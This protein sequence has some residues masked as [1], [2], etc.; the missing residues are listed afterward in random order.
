MART[1]RGRRDRILKWLS[2]VE[3][4]IRLLIELRWSDIIGLNVGHV[5][6]HWFLRHH[7]LMKSPEENVPCKL[8]QKDEETLRF[9]LYECEAIAIKRS[10]HFDRPD[11]NQEETQQINWGEI[12]DFARQLVFLLIKRKMH[13]S[14]K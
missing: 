13:N 11:W 4:N 8:C 2:S 9:S 6:G 12:L 14:S 10:D 1:E 7:L 5:R 3:P